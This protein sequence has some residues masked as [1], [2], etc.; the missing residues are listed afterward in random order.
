MNKRLALFAFLLAVA[1]APLLRAQQIGALKTGCSLAW[2][3]KASDFWLDTIWLTDPDSESILQ[4][5]K[6]L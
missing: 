4:N 6:I 3:Q 5:P 1:L 2:L